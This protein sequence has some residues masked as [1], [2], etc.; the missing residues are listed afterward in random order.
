LPTKIVTKF[1]SHIFHIN[2]ERPLKQFQTP[3]G[4]LRPGFSKKTKKDP[5]DNN[6]IFKN[7]LTGTTILRTS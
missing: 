6:L 2:F 3:F 1:Q 4:N 5:K 7:M